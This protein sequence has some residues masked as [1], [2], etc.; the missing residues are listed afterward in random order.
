MAEVHQL[1][2]R[3][4]IEEARRLTASRHERAVVEAAYQVLE[5]RTRGS[6]S[7]IPGSP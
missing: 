2:L 6:V 1:I 3:R 7:L 5:K 4:G